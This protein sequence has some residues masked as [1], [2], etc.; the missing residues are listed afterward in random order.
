M[1]SNRFLGISRKKEEFSIYHFCGD[2]DIEG[3]SRIHWQE[4]LYQ[5]L[6]GITTI[7]PDSDFCFFND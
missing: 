7:L 1:G 5:W 4:I 6:N 3:A 2:T